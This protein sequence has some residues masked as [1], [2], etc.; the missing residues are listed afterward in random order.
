MKRIEFGV[1]WGSNPHTSTITTSVLACQGCI[2][3]T[4]I[5]KVMPAYRLVGNM[6]W[7]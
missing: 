3:G 1:D 2:V 7:F 4:Y 5:R 6:M